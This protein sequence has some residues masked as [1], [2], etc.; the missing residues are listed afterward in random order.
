MVGRP[1]T[2]LII[3]S[4]NRPEQLSLCLT[5]CAQ[6]YHPAFEIIVV[7]DPAGVAAVQTHPI[8]ELVTLCPFNEPNISQARNEGIKLA[9]GDVVAFLDDDAIPEP[10]WLWHL[11]QA[12]QDKDIDAATGFTRTRNGMGF[13]S[14]AA[15]AL[16]NGQTEPFALETDE[17]VG[18][19]PPR[20]QGVK[21]EGTNMAFRR[22][23][24]AAM[25]GFD[26]AYAYY[27]DETDLNLRLAQAG[28]RTAIV[29]LA[30]VQ[31]GMAE[32]AIRRHDKAPKD[33]TQIGVSVGCF[34]RR[35][36][37]AIETDVAFERDHQ[38]KRLIRAMM[39]GLIAPGDVRRLL[40]GFD[41]GV[42][43]GLDLPLVDL[44]PITAPERAFQ[45]MPQALA[46]PQVIAG[47]LWNRRRLRRQAGLA[48]ER[49]PVTLLLLSRTA[50]YHRQRFATDG[51]WEQR[52]GLFGRSDRSD[53]LFKLWRFPARVARERKR[54]ECTR[55]SP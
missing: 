15:W 20:G 8:A 2:S 30:Q 39:D 26:P 43:R 3:V 13:Q 23:V 45:P 47:R 16:A 37:Q 33:L 6:L 14:Q 12:F 50:L 5:A 38:R 36:S 7:T 51:Y 41:Q 48:A 21:T 28:V 54:I 9:A 22:S 53:P 25:G 10:S 46:A 31:H 44:P 32:S 35:H 1:S 18:V 19:A 34:L 27:L 40:A 52:G 11:T 42:A 29:P 55:H 17:P 4:R 49:G 24:L